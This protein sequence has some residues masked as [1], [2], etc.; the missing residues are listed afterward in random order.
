[1]KIRNNN[2]NPSHQIVRF[3]LAKKL[4]VRGARLFV[5]SG[6]RKLNTICISGLSKT[7]GVSTK[8][9]QI[10]VY[11]MILKISTIK[12]RIIL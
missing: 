11:L 9:K 7:A 5:I 6:E 8:R 12:N 10:L 2:G 4:L 1:M 3:V